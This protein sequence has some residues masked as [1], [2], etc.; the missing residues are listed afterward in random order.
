MNRESDNFFDA[1]A[2]E[3]SHCLEISGAPGRWDKRR[4]ASYRATEY[5]EYD[6][7]GQPLAGEWDVI[8]AER[9]LEH[10]PDPQR[11]VDNMFKMLRAGGVLFVSTPFLI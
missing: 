5:P 11:A 2:T 10:V 3:N 1:H 6:V 8:I 4:W 9:V 7:C